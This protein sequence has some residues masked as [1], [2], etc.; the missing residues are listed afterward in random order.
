[1][2]KYFFV[3]AGIEKLTGKAKSSYQLAV[4]LIIL[5]QLV[6]VLIPS[7]NGLETIEIFEL[8]PYL[9][10]YVGEP[11]SKSLSIMSCPKIELDIQIKKTL[12]RVKIRVIIIE[13]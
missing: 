12:K 11:D 2:C 9:E 8:F 10:T 4:V 3:F 5:A 1:M 13:I 6:V 7:E